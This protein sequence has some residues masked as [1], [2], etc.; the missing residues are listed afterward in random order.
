MQAVFDVPEPFRHVKQP[1]IIFLDF[2]GIF[3]RYMSE[4]GHFDLP[5]LSMCRDPDIFARRI[6]FASGHFAQTDDTYILV[7]F[8][9]S[10]IETMWFFTQFM[11]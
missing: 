6:F 7:G 3:G 8:R 5:A 4:S 2:F 10:S 1:Y 9:G 11:I